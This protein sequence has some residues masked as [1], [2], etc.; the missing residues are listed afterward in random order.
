LR[1]WDKNSPEAKA[2]RERYKSDAADAYGMGTAPAEAAG[3]TMICL[4]N[5]A[6]FLLGRQLRKLE[7][8]FA[9]EGGFSERMYKVRR[10]ERG[11]GGN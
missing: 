9:G 4:V 10:R 6:S 8:E 11:D 1:V 7:Q 5:Q 3:N 2:V